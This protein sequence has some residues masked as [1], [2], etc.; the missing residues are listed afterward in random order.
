MFKRF[1]VRDG[2]KA[3]AKTFS[4]DG[5]WKVD[6]KNS[7]MFGYTRAVDTKSNAV[8]IENPFSVWILQGSGI[9]GLTEREYKYIRKAY[10]ASNNRYEV[11]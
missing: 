11:L 3:F 5:R 8:V 7:V 6:V 4:E 9:D 10:E 1:R 2:V